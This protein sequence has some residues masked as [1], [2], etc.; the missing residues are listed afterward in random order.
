[1]LAN[2]GRIR[3]NNTVE[4]RMTRTIHALLPVIRAMLWGN[5]KGYVHRIV[6]QRRGKRK[7]GRRKRVVRWEK[8]EAHII[9]VEEDDK[10]E[11]D[12]QNAADGKEG[13]VAGTARED[14]RE[15]SGGKEEKKSEQ[16]C[17]REHEPELKVLP[18]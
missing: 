13:K 11:D 6:E 3:V 7:T 1:M 17:W 5:E 4:E 10:P 2:Y 16:G 14:R 12:W 15:K 8:H 9:A 18:T